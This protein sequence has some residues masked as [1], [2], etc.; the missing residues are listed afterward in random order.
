[1]TTRIRL[2]GLLTAT[3]LC[4]AACGEANDVGAADGAPATASSGA[5]VATLDDEDATDTDGGDAADVDV[6]AQLLAFAECIR[7]EGFDID[8]PTVDADGNVRLPR[9]TTDSATQ[10]QGPPEGFREARDACAAHLEGLT[11]GFQ[12]GD[13]TE[14]QDR[15]LE[16]ASCMR[17]NGFEM[18]DPD[19]SGDGGGR[20]VLQDVDQND[21]S[22]EAAFSVCGDLLGDGP[23]R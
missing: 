21:P 10:G 23:G 17:D 7:G 11:L 15:L 4:A 12:G 5:D 14:Q 13:Q 2:I 22:Y 19:F 9:P 20:R 16:F 8:D 3:V 1:M 6:E 18:A